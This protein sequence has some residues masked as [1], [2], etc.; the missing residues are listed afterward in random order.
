MESS[1]SK[2]SCDQFERFEGA[3]VAPYIAAF[4]EKVA[5]AQESEKTIYRCR[6]CGRAWERRETPAGKKPSLVRASV[7]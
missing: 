7:E 4:L 6:L 1:Q 5:A 3:S 2:C